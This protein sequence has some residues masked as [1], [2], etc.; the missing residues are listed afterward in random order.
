MAQVAQ[1]ARRLGEVPAGLDVAATTNV[2]VAEQ[3]VRDTRPDTVRH[4]LD[5]G[6]E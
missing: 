6:D 2:D 4:R 5:L 3:L 1:R